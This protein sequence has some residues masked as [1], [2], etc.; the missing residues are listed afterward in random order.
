MK[1][2]TKVILGIIVLIILWV[3]YVA[4]EKAQYEYKLNAPQP[5]PSKIVTPPFPSNKVPNDSA[6]G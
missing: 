3:F 6:K 2:S 5:L 1:T 4:Y